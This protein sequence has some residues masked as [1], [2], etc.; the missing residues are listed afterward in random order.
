MTQPAETTGPI[1]VPVTY[2][3]EWQDGFGARGWKLDIAIDDAFVIASTAYT[4]GNIP[5]SVLIHDIVDHHLCGFTLSGH[6]DE[7]M[8]L[9]QLRERTG[10]DIRPDYSQMVDEDILQGLVNGEAPETFLPPDLARQLPEQGT[11]AERMHALRKRIG[12]QALR[13]RLITRFFELGEQGRQ[14]AEQAWRRLG[15]EYAQRAAIALALQRLLERAD[16]WML[17]QDIEALQ[18]RFVITPEECRLEMDGQVW[19]DKP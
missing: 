17:E 16:A 7:A 11:P 18:G 13:E 4:G 15:L 5:T 14:R 12:E 6:R 10:T 2:R 9:V 19:E 3:R 1:D 8:A